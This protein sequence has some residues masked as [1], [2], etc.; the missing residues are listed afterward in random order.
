MLTE[1]RMEHDGEC[2]CCGVS[3]HAGTQAY[4][5]S[6]MSAGI[7]GV[8]CIKCGDLFLQ[9]VQAAKQAAKTDKSPRTCHKCYRE[10]P[11]AECYYVCCT[12]CEAVSKGDKSPPTGP[13]QDD[14]GLGIA[15]PTSHG[16]GVDFIGNL[17]QGTAKPPPQDDGGPAYPTER[18]EITDTPTT[19]GRH[20]TRTYPGMSLRTRAAIELK[21]EDSEVPLVN[22]MIRKSRRDW[23]AGLVLGGQW[24]ERYPEDI[25]EPATME[26]VA[27]T[28]YRLADAMLAE[29]SKEPD[30]G[31]R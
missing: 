22:D 29:S 25:R 4:D 5:R 20:I 28:C 30:D 2:A 19:V 17:K 7:V 6:F 26:T 27:A 10:I 12:A 16:T 18:D 23:L 14:G 8:W 21:V 13:K 11:K 9:G 15:W 31:E 1:K 3:L 24:S